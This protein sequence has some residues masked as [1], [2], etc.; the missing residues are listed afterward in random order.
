[1]TAGTFL[2]RYRFL[3]PNME[4]VVRSGKLTEEQQEEIDEFNRTLQN[5][6]KERGATFVSRTTIYSPKYAARSVEL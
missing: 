4:E 6:Q 5:E 2:H 3:P 1:M